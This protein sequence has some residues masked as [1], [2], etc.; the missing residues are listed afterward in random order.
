GVIY[1]NEILDENMNLHPLEQQRELSRQLRQIGLGIMGVADMFI[2]MGIRYGSNESLKLIDEIGH[3]LVNEAL[4]QSALLAKEDGPFPRY[5]AEK[6]LKSPFLLANA[7]EEVLELI[8]EH[9]LRNS[10]VLTIAPTGSIST[11]IGCSNGV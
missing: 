8:R 5:R 4:R 10:Q 6:V 11:L 1:L 2:M 3:T 9:G 7:D